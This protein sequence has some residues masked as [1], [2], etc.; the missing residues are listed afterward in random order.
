MTLF[1]QAQ[2]PKT[3]TLVMGFSQ[4]KLQLYQHT[5][6][7]R[8]SSGWII[9]SVVDHT[10]SISNYFLSWKS[11]HKITKRIRPSAKKID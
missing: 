9:D 7:F 8:K 6:I 5:K 4:P 3:V 10:I 1:I 11:L 2:K